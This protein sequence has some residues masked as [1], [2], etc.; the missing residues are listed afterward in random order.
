L[1]AEHAGYIFRWLFTQQKQSECEV[2]SSTMAATKL[3]PIGTSKTR[4]NLGI[5][6]RLANIV[7]PLNL[8]AGSAI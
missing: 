4:S 5:A 3:T 2:G 1:D 7:C 8:G 6:N